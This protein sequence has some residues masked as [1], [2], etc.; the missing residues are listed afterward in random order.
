MSGMPAWGK[1]MDDESI[2]GMV[3]FLRLLP[4]MSEA[5]YREWV[6]SSEGHVHEPAEKAPVHAHADGSSHEH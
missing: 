2:W 5:R 1:S 3:A 4:D 6:D